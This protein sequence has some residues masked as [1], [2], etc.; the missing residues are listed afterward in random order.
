[1]VMPSFSTRSEVIALLQHIYP[2]AVFSM[3]ETEKGELNARKLP[4]YEEFA[5]YISLIIKVC[6]HAKV[7]QRN[8]FLVLSIN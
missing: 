3:Y 2:E 5:V 8:R 4:A 6:F 7:E 1:M